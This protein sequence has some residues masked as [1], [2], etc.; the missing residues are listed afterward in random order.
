M[1][2]CR[3]VLKAGMLAI[4]A[5]LASALM[6]SSVFASEPIQGYN[7]QVPEA[8]MTPDRVDTRIGTL[9][10]FDGPHQGDGRAGLRQP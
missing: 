8:I 1:N 4:P 10:F 7:T 6:M 3:T 5:V 9:K 2:L